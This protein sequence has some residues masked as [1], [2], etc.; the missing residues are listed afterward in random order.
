MNYKNIFLKLLDDI[1]TWS[2]LKSKL[3]IYNTSKTDTT[4]KDTTAGK[5]FEYFAKYYFLADSEQS[6]LYTDVWLYEEIDSLL[7]EEL[8]LPSID[9]GV[10]LLLKDSQGR[11]TVVQCKF[12]NNEESIV[13]F[14]KDKLANTFF[15]SKNCFG[16]ILFTNVSDCTDDV[17]NE[18]NFNV[19]KSDTLL[20]LDTEIFKSIKNYIV[21]NVPLPVKKHQPQKHQTLAIEKVVEHFVN[22]DRGQLIL[23]CGAGK[24][25]TSLWIKEALKSKTT[26]V[27][28]PSLAL[29]RQFKT[30]W[31][32]QRSENYIYIN[33]CS[34]KDIDKNKE[35]SSIIHTYEIS[36]E[37]TTSTER[38]KEFLLSAFDNK[39]IFC[40]YQS[41][42][43]IQNALI[44][45]PIFSFDLIICDEAHR[46]S[47]GAKKNTF[48]IV[49]DQDKIKANKRLYMTATPRVVSAQ[50]KAKLGNEYALLC[51]M[52]NPE[53][54]GGEAFRMSFGE[55]IVEKILVDYKII[56]IGVTEKQVKQFIDQ[57]RYVTE[58]YDLKDIAN[59]Y[60]LNLVMDKYAAHHAIT[61]HSKVDFAKDFSIRHN[62]YFGKDIYSNHVSGKDKTSKR[63]DILRKFKNH[64]KGVVSN[65]RCLTEGVD[66]PI[67]DLIYFCDPKNSKI[68]IVQA[69]G[70]ALRKDRHGKKPI[71]YI[72]VPIFHH[73]E[74][75]I[76][77]EI[78]NKPDFKNLIQVV[79]SLC[80]QDERLQ[81]EIDEIAFSKGERISRRLEISYN[82]ED[83]DKIITFEGLE[84]EVKRYLFDQI[85]EKTKDSWNVMYA[86]LVK[87]KKIYNTTS[88]TKK[89]T[90]FKNLNWWV[91]SQR[92]AYFEKRLSS[93]HFEKLMK[94]G[95]EWKGEQRREITDR[96][97]IWMESYRKLVNYFTDNG[98]VDIP[99]RYEKDNS[100][101]TWL[102]AQRIKYDNDKLSEN[103]IEL[104]ENVNIN[105]DPKNTYPE[106][107]EALTKYKSEFG[108]TAVSQANFSYR[109]LAAKCSRIRAI[110]RSGK[111]TKNGDLVAQQK[112]R[113]TKWAIEKLNELGFEW[114][115]GMVDWNENF[116]LLKKYYNE[117]GNSI[118]KSSENQFL[119]FWSYRQRRCREDLEPEQ[120]E[121]LESINFSFEIKKSD[122]ENAFLEKA[123]LLKEYYD[124][125]NN[126]VADFEREFLRKIQKWESAF[127]IS[128][129]AGNLSS[130]KFD[131]L[132]E[133]NFSFL[134]EN[135]DEKAWEEKYKA[136]VEFYNDY[137]T[138]FIPDDYEFVKL[139][140]WL[141]YQRGLYL[142]SNLKEDRVEKLLSLGY[143]FTIIYKSV[144]DKTKELISN[145]FWQKKISELKNYLV[146]N[147]K[148]DKIEKNQDSISLYR[149]IKKVKSLYK[150]GGLSKEKITEL[151]ESGFD[152]H[153]V[154]IREKKAKREKSDNWNEK[155]EDLKIFYSTNGTFY[156][157]LKSDENKGLAS[158]LRAQR[159]LYKQN[160]LSDTKI[161][162]LNDIGFSFIDNYKIK[163]ERSRKEKDN[164]KWD[165]KFELFKKY[166]N[167][168]NTF[169]IQI[170][171]KANEKLRIWVQ[172]LISNFRR[173]KLS[174][175]RI[176]RLDSIGFRFEQ[177]QIVKAKIIKPIKEKVFYD[178]LWNK[179]YLKLITYKIQNRDCNVLRSFVNAS[180]GSW[181]FNQRNYRRQNKLSNEKI[182]KLNLLEFRWDEVKNISEFD[183]WNK[184][185]TK[186]KSLFEKSGHSSPKKED[187]DEQLISWV[188]QQRH[189][190]KKGKLKKEY[191]DLLSNLNFDWNPDS[192]TENITQWLV[193]YNTL[194]DYKNKFGTLKVSQT[195]KTYR[196][197]GRWVNDQRVAFK[198]NK[199]SDFKL[200]KLNDIS[201][202]WDGRVGK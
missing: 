84:K 55:A 125:I 6:Q 47:G 183:V 63:S 202:I 98:D 74:D 39:I 118:V 35:D 82:D 76:E 114:N 187:G 119:F 51:D 101:A 57:R 37:V 14:G 4:E 105:W 182:E 117:F 42:E 200:S 81:A 31:A 178:E 102:V 120:I 179:Q 130:E 93:I 175:E 161:N 68:D 48:A 85:I 92:D 79:R 145:T 27:L 69:S 18:K 103:Q 10:D 135:L 198:R 70:R 157:S 158:W 121:K 38:I 152:F 97:E 3:E 166:Y 77:K 45:L 170:T 137:H 2:E 16:V 195:D 32:E 139:K 154:P 141:Q 50:L 54:Y 80:D 1:S 17:K 59:N 87:F 13:H 83:I 71:G 148:I 163:K 191:F 29:L 132:N 106:F 149:W 177:N 111:P 184:S 22:N 189:R 40:T 8:G 5:L 140:R 128:Y 134:Q 164:T 199:L 143:D 108:N 62:N 73:I 138:F 11:Y 104:L 196:A 180:L 75:D 36:G 7:K 25:T 58:N 126:G 201:F 156:I 115:L 60:A 53:I 142:K 95:F 122:D 167:D 171:D 162:Q 169:Y 190:N 110:Y 185:Y 52:S 91:Q 9:K 151:K 133:I 49:H 188:Q 33:V 72:V 129:R 172:S 174:D 155:F 123:S 99:A 197:L 96:F 19:I 67:I 168:N 23:P 41:I 146:V 113:L 116:V 28:F 26:L 109:R 15:W 181:V 64:N 56:G 65:A 46:T 78:E 20:N 176:G 131:I 12:K 66:V 21:I 34:E 192:I 159:S 43:V 150:N 61:F 89:H 144:S 127:R 147:S 160:K 90:D 136:L 153:Y 100:L 86:N 30:E 165:E 194:L 44:L 94:I 186:L 173:K 193:N 24:T 88:V 124:N 112:G 107:I